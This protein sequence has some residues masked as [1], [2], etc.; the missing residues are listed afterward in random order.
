MV[1]IFGVVILCIWIGAQLIHYLYTFFYE[2]RYK[3]FDFSIFEVNVGDT[4]YVD[5]NSMS[6]RLATLYIKKHRIPKT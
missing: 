1:D 6:R 4:T 5:V 3:D 2:L